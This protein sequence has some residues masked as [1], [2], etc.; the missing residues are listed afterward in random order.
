M[1]KTYNMKKICS[2]CVSDWHFITM[3]TPYINQKL[4]CGE[5]V[6]ILSSKDCTLI[7]KIFLSKLTLNEKQKE[8]IENLNWNLHDL[9]NRIDLIKDINNYENVTII[10]KGDNNYIENINRNL[11]N[12]L[13][14]DMCKRITLVNC[15]EAIQANQEIEEILKNHSKVLNTSGEKNIEEVFGDIVKK[16]EEVS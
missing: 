14:N 6:I 3:I 13:K 8:Q 10:I 7:A 4:K 16:N 1:E 11:K 15:F 12:V 5:K 2:F 9:N